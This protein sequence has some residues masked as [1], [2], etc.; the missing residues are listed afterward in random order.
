MKIVTFQLPSRSTRAAI[1]IIDTVPSDW[2]SIAGE[3][4]APKSAIRSGEVCASSGFRLSSRHRS[5]HTIIGRTERSTHSEENLY[6]VQLRELDPDLYAM[7]AERKLPGFVAFEEAGGGDTSIVTFDLARRIASAYVKRGYA[8][9][10]DFTSEFRTVRKT[11][12]ERCVVR[13][14]DACVELAWQD[15]YGGREDRLTPLFDVCRRVGRRLSS[16]SDA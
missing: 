5:Q 3:L 2:R 16:S 10:L 15:A 4:H 8:G 6:L 12:S 9:S 7:M 1:E 14:A 13:L 11:F